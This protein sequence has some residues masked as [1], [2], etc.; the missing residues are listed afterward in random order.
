MNSL[1]HPSPRSLSSP[2]CHSC[3]TG[4]KGKF[5]H[6]PNC[7]LNFNSSL[8]TVVRLPV[9]GLGRNVQEC[10]D[11]ELATLCPP[12]CC[13]FFHRFGKTWKQTW[14]CFKRYCTE[15]RQIKD[16][17]ENTCIVTCS[18]QITNANVPECFRS[19]LSVTPANVSALCFS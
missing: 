6:C 18:S 8:G 4:K 17:F 9:Q 10:L 3:V 1:S 2:N 5:M 14:T 15:C 7:P 16:D 12:H 19:Q 13:R 11:S